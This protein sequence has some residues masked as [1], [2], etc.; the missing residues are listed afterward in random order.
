[1]LTIG[2]TGGIGSGKSAAAEVFAELGA[3]V[4]DTDHIS[5]ELTGPHGAAMAAIVAAFGE[6]VRRADGGLDRDA[7]RALAFDSPEARRRLEAILHPLIRAETDRRCRQST[8]A[9]V[10]LVVPLLIESGAYRSRIDRTCVV[11]VPETVQVRRV[12]LRNGFDEDRVRSIMAAQVDR[13]SRL[14]EAD[15][16]ID[17]SGDLAALRAQVEVLH[18]RYLGLAQGRAGCP[19]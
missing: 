3:T 17:N 9:Y 11:D 13:R 14:A 7:M 12:G 1:M 2:L 15:D 5:H 19:S 6:R 18:A 8:G 10:V 16:V 4:V